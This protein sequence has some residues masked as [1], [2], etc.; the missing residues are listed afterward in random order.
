[1]SV[2]QDK[3][4]LITGAASG[5][6]RELAKQLSAL[7]ARIGGLD[8]QA[9]PLGTLGTELAGRPYTSAVSDV[10]DLPALTAAAQTLERT[11]GPTDML[12]A[13]A[14]IGR[15]TLATQDHA[16]DIDRIIRINLIGLSNSF[17]AVLPGMIT[18]K[19]GQLVA[20]SS[21]ASFSGIPRMA[22][23]CASKAGV[24]ALCDAYRVEL[25]EHGIAVTTL[26]PGFIRTPMTDHL[27]IPK[28]EL[29][30][31][32]RRMIAAIAARKT[33][34][35]FPAGVTF[36]VRLLRYL[37][38]WLRDWLA[39]RYPRRGVLKKPAGPGETAS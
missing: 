15:E 28:L 27:D 3:V 39:T 6:G 11:L 23:Y 7:G 12:I 26:C 4:V 37:S 8:I 5:I 36:Q 2:F 38:T 21:L 17:S 31:A 16:A 33:Y 24:N 18:R 13:A 14:G 29:T 10:T 34:A 35:A 20:L 19:R 22:G 9:D 32:V 25:R 30:P 1:M